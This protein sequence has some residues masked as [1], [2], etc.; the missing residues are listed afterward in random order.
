[1]FC[2]YFF[3]ILSASLAVIAASAISD[4]EKYLLA[5]PFRCE[6]SKQMDQWTT[7]IKSKVFISRLT[8]N[9]VKYHNHL[10]CNGRFEKKN[11]KREKYNYFCVTYFS[12]EECQWHLHWTK[13]P[14]PPAFYQRD[15]LVQL[16]LSNAFWKG[17]RW[18]RESRWWKTPLHMYLWIEIEKEVKKRM[19]NR[20][21]TWGWFFTD[22]C[23]FG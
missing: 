5:H 15:T 21:L 20:N 6:H 19:N 11:R 4:E 12:E 18:H 10:I 2:L 23:V 13:P 9:R 7:K 8:P 17:A 3:L 14:P 16:Q 1:M 22:T